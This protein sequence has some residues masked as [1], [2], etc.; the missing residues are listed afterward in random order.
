MGWVINVPYAD[1]E[2]EKARYKKYYPIH[3]QKSK[4]FWDKNKD[5][6]NSER[7][8]RWK[9]DSDYRER[10]IISN[11][12][13][14]TKMGETGKCLSMKRFML[15]TGVCLICG[16]ANFPIIKN[17]HVTDGMIVSLCANHHSYF[18]Q[19][20]QTVHRTFMAKQIEHSS[21]LWDNK[22]GV[23]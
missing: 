13:S 16:T 1:K 14:L 5:R 11:K 20:H 15:G 10:K 4:E 23:D 19:S 8:R 21:F 17:H 2:K 18:G 7:R 6:L 9:E 3:K 22:D 12:K